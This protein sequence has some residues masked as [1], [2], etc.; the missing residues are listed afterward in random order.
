MK[1]LIAAALLLSTPALAQAPAYQSGYCDPMRTFM[2]C[3]AKPPAPPPAAQRAEAPKA[4]AIRL[5][6]PT[7]GALPPR[8]KLPPVPGSVKR[9]LIF[10]VRQKRIW[11]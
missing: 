7:E 4:P 6:P 5:A 1:P 9:P 8:A 3:V 10:P 11:I 2:M